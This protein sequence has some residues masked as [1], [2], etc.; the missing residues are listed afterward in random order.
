MEQ[1]VRTRFAPSPTGFMHIG[2]LR[3]CLYAFLFARKNNGTFIL[4]I[5]DTDQERFVDGAVDLIYRTLKTSGITHDEGPDVGGDYGPY[6]QSERKP[7]YM[8]YAKKLIELG[9]AYYCFCTRERLETL[10]DENGVRTYDKHC[11]HLSKEEIEENLKNGVPYVIRQNIPKVGTGT[12]HDMVYGDISVDYSEL[13]DNILIKS[14][15]MPT[16][17]FA[18]V[19]DDHLMKITHVIRGVEYLSS[20]PKY[21]LI[22]DAFGWERPQYMHLPPIMKDASHKLSKRYGDANFEDFINK[23][24][25]PEAIINYI[26]LLGWSPKDNTEKMSM[27]ELIEKFDVSGLSKSGSIFDEAKMRWL[28]Q[29]YVKELPFEKFMEYARPYFDKSCAKGKYDYD[30]LGRILMSRV[31]IFSEIPDKVAFLDEYGHFDTALFVH[32]KSKTTIELAR[33]ILEK[34]LPLYEGVDEWTNE[35][36]FKVSEEFAAANGYKKQQLLGGA[37]CRRRSRRYPRRRNRAYGHSWQKRKFTSHKLCVNIIL[38]QFGGNY[39]T[40]VNA[41][42]NDYLFRFVRRG[43]HGTDTYRVLLRSVD[44]ENSHEKHVAGR[45][46]Y[47]DERFHAVL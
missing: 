8:E 11:L 37:S 17:N 7:I 42:E 3:T 45:R 27:E 30:K 38:I 13:E 39:E 40:T 22:Y 20:T 46:V 32:Q 29:L 2:N 33:E 14:D 9:G 47:F 25:L 10:T 21:N 41:R 28:N 16:Y 24:F 15:G 6:I 5:E 4:R 31:E 23:G 44:F 43:F 19:V 34:I 26:S 12:Y 1:K 36:L 35:N 18:N